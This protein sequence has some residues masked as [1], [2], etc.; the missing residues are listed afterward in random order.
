MA[1][2]STYTAM[3]EGNRV[4]GTADGGKQGELLVAEPK[5]ETKRPPFFKVVLLNDDYTPMEFVVQVLK[6]VF[7]KMHEEAVGIMLEVH[8][9]GAG[10]CGV[11]T[12]DV[13][14]TKAETVVTVARRHEYP[15]QCVVERA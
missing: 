9:R 12:R 2:M 7:H 1:I 14:E 15:L 13:A 8:H 6:E 4:T 5:A 10:T 11:F 3:S